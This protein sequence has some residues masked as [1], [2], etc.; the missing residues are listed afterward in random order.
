MK[1]KITIERINDDDNNIIVDTLSNENVI[2][3]FN[4]DPYDLL[5]PIKAFADYY[6]IYEY[7]ILEAVQTLFG[8]HIKELEVLR[9]NV[10]E[11]GGDRGITNE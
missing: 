9:N 2:C 4:P 8:C 10:G 6:D 7:E 3:D 11:M 1:L 5:K